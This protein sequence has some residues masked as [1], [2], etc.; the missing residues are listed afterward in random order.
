MPSIFSRVA[1]TPSRWSRRN[2][3]SVSLAVDEIDPRRHQLGGQSGEAIDLAVVDQGIAG[4]RVDARLMAAVEIDDGEAQ[5][6]EGDGAADMDP[7]ASG[8]R[9]AMGAS[10]PRSSASSAAVGRSG[11]R[12]KPA[13]PHRAASPQSILIVLR[14]I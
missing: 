11:S 9:C 10:M 8:P 7:V 5:M 6:A 2:S 13:K 3:T 14:T 12:R 4:E 1:A